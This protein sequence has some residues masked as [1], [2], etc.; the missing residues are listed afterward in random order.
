MKENRETTLENDDYSLFFDK[1][2]NL[3]V[4]GLS[5]NEDRVSNKVAKKLMKKGFNLIPIYPKE[6]EILGKKVYR[7][8]EDV[9][10][11][12]DV[13]II[14]LRP[15]LLFDVVKSAVELGIDKV[16]LQEKVISPEAYEYA[17]QHNIKFVMNRCYWK[18][19]AEF[20]K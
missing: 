10:E 17:A 2:F 18:T 8:L 6:D 13:V 7:K 5:P 4:V 20:D 1:S 15:E 9:E 12:I 3:A 16:W 11:K 19:F 14:F